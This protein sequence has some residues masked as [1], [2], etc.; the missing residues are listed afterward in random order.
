V[1]GWEYCRRYSRARAEATRCKDNVA[2]KELED[3]ATAHETAPETPR[4]TARSR[5]V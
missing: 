1:Q 5:K 3:L 2:Q 4:S